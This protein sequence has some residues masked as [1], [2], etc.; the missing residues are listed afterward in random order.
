M[1][2]PASKGATVAQ[3]EGALPSQKGAAFENKNSLLRKKLFEN[4]KTILR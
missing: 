2:R 4:K 1:K 3:K